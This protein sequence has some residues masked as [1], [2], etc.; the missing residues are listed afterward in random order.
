MEANMLRITAGALLFLLFPLSAMAQSDFPKAEVF[1][2]Y[3][4]FRANPLGMNL[5]GWNASVTG[6]V[7]R[8]FG[9]E[10]DFSGHY[11]SPNVYGFTVPFVDVHS[12]AFMGGPKL[13]FRGGSATAFAHFLIGG[14]NA[15]TSAF[16][17]SVSNTALAAA[18]G[19]GVDLNMNESIAI[20]VIQADY[21]MTRHDTSPQVFMSGFK[22]RQN[23]F[24]FSAGI[25]FKLGK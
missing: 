23:N 18:I 6:N 15:G 3:S 8:Y 13:S 24:R 25:V 19:G 17:V 9:I 7:T 22:E 5:H 20:R 10:G 4:Y 12:H 16:N 11:G 2:G 1:G 14:A 21:L